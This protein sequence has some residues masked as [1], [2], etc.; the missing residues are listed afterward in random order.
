MLLM[1][2]KLCRLVYV[3]VGSGVYLGD[4][5]REQ[6]VLLRR[7]SCYSDVFSELFSI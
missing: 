2:A 4:G 6:N 7:C 1:R 3:C 5:N